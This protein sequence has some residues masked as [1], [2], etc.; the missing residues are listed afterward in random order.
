MSHNFYASR[1]LRLLLIVF[2][3]PFAAIGQTVVF[4]DNCNTMA[5]W[6]NT[7]GRYNTANVQIATGAI[8][9]FQSVAPVVPPNDHTGGGNVLYTNGNTPYMQAGA[10]NY[11]LYRIESV[12]INLTGYDNTRLEFWMQLRS[13]TGNWDGCYVEWSHDGVNWSQIPANN[14]CLAYDGPM[15]LNPS[16]TPFYPLLRPAWFNFRTQ[17]T[18]VLADISAWDNVPAFYLRYTFHSDEALSDHGWALDDISI[19]SV[20]IPQVQGNN[21]VINHNDLT[22]QIPDGT[23]FGA[24]PIGGTGVQTFCIHNIG[25][26]PL[27]LTGN[28]YVQIIGSADFTVIS[29]PANN[30]IP[31]GGSECFQVQFAPTTVG[32]ANATISIPNSDDYS[33]CSP[34]NPYRYAVRGQSLNTPPVIAGLVD[35]TVCP[36]SGPITLN[37]TVSDVEQN[38]AIITLSGS[39]SN[40]TLVPNGNIAFGGS[41]TNRTVTVTPAPGQT[42][43][44]VI[45]VTANDQQS[46][47][48]DSTF[49]FTIN[50]EDAQ[51]PV[52][53]CQNL[54]VQLDANGQGSITP[55]QADNGSTDNCQI[56]SVSVSQQNFTCADVGVVPVTLTVTDFVGNSATCQ[57]NVTVLPPPMNVNYTASDYNGFNISCFGYSDGSISVTATGGCAPL[58]YAWSHDPNL[59][60]S[61]AQNL[62]QGNYMVTVTDAAGQQQQLNINLTEPAQLADNGF[63]SNI[64][65]FGNLDGSVTLDI[66]GGVPPYT[67]SA[68]PVDQNL[69]AGQYSY[70]ITD[71]NNCSIS[72]QHTITEP[73]QIIL[74]GQDRYSIFCKEETLLDIT[75]GGGTGAFTYTWSPADFLSCATCEDPV[76]TP[77]RNI[78][79]SVTATDQEGCSETFLI[80]VDVI[81]YAFIPNSFTPN[82][83]GLNDIFYV[84]SAVLD[85]LE[86]R[87]FDRW[88]EEVFFSTK[89]D[90]GWNG[91]KFNEGKLLPAGVYAYSI[92]ITLPGELTEVYNGN[93]NLIR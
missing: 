9:N 41:G 3:F 81:C 7:G 56:A 33:Q 59:V 92:K 66:A 61:S 77:P 5:N 88:G 39:S 14:L 31:P 47:N 34:P 71:L 4:F 49:Y 70:T 29:Q 67:Y 22:P 64:S 83:D 76:S 25:E 40:V 32:T 23:D 1:L 44:S 57:L 2:L 12:P 15:T 28:P 60:T 36:N 18:R 48:P 69:P 13:E 21:I 89:L 38:P 45:A 54:Q 6:N 46:V 58:T 75:A 87:I 53:I 74:S 42:G 93:I 11:L 86:V 37:F 90:Y 80:S 24:V 26:S 73:P 10:L 27:T 51:P 16:S 62:P 19:I 85:Q 8:Y 55:Q 84:E 35:T 17:W 20:A 30:V 52:A 50:V 82:G 72:V 79:Y 63:A 91:K 78:T 68:G 43:T 65:C